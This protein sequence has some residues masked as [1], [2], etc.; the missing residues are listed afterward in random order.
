MMDWI[1]YNTIKLVHKVEER[2]SG[3]FMETRE[4]KF[5]S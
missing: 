2:K 1:K 5:R 4:R 3:N